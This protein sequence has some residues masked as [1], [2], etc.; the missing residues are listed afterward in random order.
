MKTK[1]ATVFGGSGFI[2]R[3][4]VQKLA[5]AGYV[6]RIP[7]R[8]IDKAGILRTAGS[9]GQIVPMFCSLRRPEMI[10]AAV[11]GADV[12][13]NLIGILHESMFKALFIWPV[14]MHRP[15]FHDVHHIA[16]E[17]IAKAASAAGVLRLV[18]ISAI[19]ADA[20]GTSCYA[21]SKA[22]GEAAVREAF[23][24]ATILRPSIVFGPEDDFFNRFAGLT[25]VSPALPL[26]GGGMTKFQPVYVGDVADAVMAAITRADAMGKTYELG[27][28]RVASFKELLELMLSVTHRQRCLITLPFGIAKLKS[29]VLQFAPNPMLTPDQVELLR[30]DNIVAEGA[31]KLT[32]LGITPTAMEA[33][34]PAYLERFIPG[35][36]F[37]KSA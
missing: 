12:V 22:A 36:T 25:R 32:D 5:A 20:S 28:P 29:Y 33:I 24:A 10:E 26:I 9:V 35:G 17:N 7:T 27:G 13:I 31:L 1:V 2:G 15:K 14:K 19:G 4:V 3:Q 34:L 37:K 11:K 18:Q 30:K 16:A 6:V 23:P 8:D 21:R